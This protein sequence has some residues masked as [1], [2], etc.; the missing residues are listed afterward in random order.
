MVMAIGQKHTT[1]FFGLSQQ[2]IEQFS[3]AA[4]ELKKENLEQ[5]APRLKEI[6]SLMHDFND[7]FQE[8]P[9]QNKKW[10]QEAGMD[11]G[12]KQALGHIF[13]F[14]SDRQ[15]QMAYRPDIAAL[16]AALLEEA[17]ILSHNLGQN[18]LEEEYRLGKR[19]EKANPSKQ[20]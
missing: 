9:P 14:A 1:E 5:N 4:L 18:N 2:R 20:S 11:I 13:A 16:V 6:I 7:H 10:V 17:T 19:V 12:I 3:Q 8:I 15:K